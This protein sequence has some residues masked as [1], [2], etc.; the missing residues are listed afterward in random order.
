MSLLSLVRAPE[1]GFVSKMEEQFG[2]LSDIWYRYLDEEPQD[3]DKCSQPK[4]KVQKLQIE[5]KKNDAYAE[6]NEGPI[7][8]KD[9]RAK[10]PLL[11]GRTSSSELNLNSAVVSVAELA[12]ERAENTKLDT[13]ASMT[14][15]LI[16]GECGEKEHE[17]NTMQ[18]GIEGS[19]QMVLLPGSSKQ[20]DTED[21]RME[22]IDMQH[23]SHTVVELAHPDESEGEKN[24]NAL[25][26]HNKVAAIPS[27][28]P[29]KGVDDGNKS[30]IDNRVRRNIGGSGTQFMYRKGICLPAARSIAMEVQN[31]CTLEHLKVGW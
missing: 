18:K 17:E 1:D 14:K 26:F 27:V 3:G 13:P 24:L 19:Q 15:E 28:Y 29:P 11:K 31:V 8:N 21:E 10:D 30:V 6:E 23:Q 7:Q 4:A 20:D 9:K 12:S 25:D 22:V 2:Q 16:K 5:Q